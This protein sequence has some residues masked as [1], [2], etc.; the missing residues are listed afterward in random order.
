MVNKVYACLYIYIYTCLCHIVSG[1]IIGVSVLEWYCNLFAPRTTPVPNQNRWEPPGR[2]N[3][4]T[5]KPPRTRTE[6]PQWLGTAPQL[7]LEPTKT[8]QNHEP[9]A[10]NLLNHPQTNHAGSFR[11]H[12]RTNTGSTEASS[13]PDRLRDHLEHRKV[14]H[15]EYRIT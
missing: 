13:G 5:S 2:T 9:T 6:P 12:P 14:D 1:F 8:I 10:Q 4:G 7:T 15:L 3:T 11:N